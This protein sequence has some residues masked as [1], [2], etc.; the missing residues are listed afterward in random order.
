VIGDV[1]EGVATTAAATTAGVLGAAGGGPAAPIT[2]AT[3]AALAGGATTGLF[4]TGRQAIAKGLEARDRF[5]PGQVGVATAT[6]AVIPTLFTGAGGLLRGASKGVTKILDKAVKRPI[7]AENADEIIKAGKELGVKA[8]PEQFFQDRSVTRAANSL[9]EM[10]LTLFGRGLRKSKIKSEE[11]LDL[12]IRDLF[13]DRLN[14]DKSELGTKISK[15]LSDEVLTKAKAA[16]AIYKPF[17][18][19]F[20]N[21]ITKPQTTQI[22]RFLKKR[23]KDSRNDREISQAKN[24]LEKLT[25]KTKTLNDLKELK[26][27]IGANISAELQPDKQVRSLASQMYK[28]VTGLRSKTLSD[29]TKQAKA[30]NI[31]LSETKDS[32]LI[33]LIKASDRK[34]EFFEFAKGEIGKADKLWASIFKDAETLGAGKR[35]SQKF[36]GK[37][38]VE[39]FFTG[40]KLEKIADKIFDISDIRRLRVFKDR[41]PDQFE[42]LRKA[43]I[44]DIYNKATTQVRSGPDKVTP[45]MLANQLKATDKATLKLLFGGDDNVIDALITWGKSNPR[46]A[47]PSGTDLM[48]MVRV[49]KIIGQNFGAMIQS[50][51]LWAKTR[52]ISKKQATLEVVADFLDGSLG[53]K[54]KIAPALGIAIKR[55]QQKEDVAPPLLP[56]Q[57]ERQ[58]LL[59]PQR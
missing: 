15:E 24:W 45:R 32:P 37:E 23:I 42:I 52:G 54:S 28:R 20:G 5:D 10:N 50:A 22:A 49:P 58:P 1:V 13:S 51:T 7:L 59:I 31:L 53:F 57:A 29:L 39:E 9:N 17:D 55:G 44:S 18:I 30:G 36:T 41:F 27:D 3:A 43:K 35:L 47:N 26:K 4:E 48:N 19:L 25:T 56:P 11:E 34:E 33:N 14:I 46:P 12:V 16:E 6:G 21:K 38:V 2:G 8:S 40:T